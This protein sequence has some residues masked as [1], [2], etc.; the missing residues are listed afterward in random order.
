M[1]CTGI[2]GT[3]VIPERQFL[4]DVNNS[5][6]NVTITLPTK[7]IQYPTPKTTK[8]TVAP[9]DWKRF[10]DALIPGYQTLAYSPGSD[11]ITTHAFQVGNYGEKTFLY[12]K[13]F[14]ISENG[15]NVKRVRFFHGLWMLNMR[16]PN[17]GWLEWELDLSHE[18]SEFSGSI[19]FVKP[20]RKP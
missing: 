5:N 7:E 11:L 16:G 13:Q 8:V 14:I 12:G 1:L 4:E 17:E 3:T 15:N 6:E 9:G 20:V 10:P 2:Y 19:R 18:N